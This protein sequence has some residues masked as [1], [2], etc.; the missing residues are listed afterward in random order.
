M[1]C[2]Y[3]CI[4]QLTTHTVKAS[5]LYYA[6]FIMYVLSFHHRNIHVFPILMLAGYF[7][8]TPAFMTVC[9]FGGNVRKRG[10]GKVILVSCR[11]LILNQVLLL[12][13][14]R[15]MFLFSIICK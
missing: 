3:L 13:H 15:Y 6:P 10:V 8:F 11:L 12:V 1:F 14:Y 2:V 4:N 9:H 7:M 5:V